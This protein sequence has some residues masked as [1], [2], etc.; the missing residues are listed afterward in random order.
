VEGD[1]DGDPVVSG[2]AAGWQLDFIRSRPGTARSA[3]DHV[4][5]HALDADIVTA[6]RRCQRLP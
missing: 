1:F 2:D 5:A 4:I 6:M 3:E